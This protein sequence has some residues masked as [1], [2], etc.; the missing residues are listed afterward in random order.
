MNPEQSPHAPEQQPAQP[1]PIMQTQPV[2]TQPQQ[3]T[4]SSPAQNTSGERFAKKTKNAGRT[5]LI[6]GIFI[7]VFSALG[8]LAS[9]TGTSKE[10]SSSDIVIALVGMAVF[11][12]SAIVMIIQGRKL[13]RAANL[14]DAQSAITVSLV[15]SGVILLI[16]IASS[17][18]SQS[19]LSIIGFLT[20]VTIIYLFVVK[21]GI[22]KA[23]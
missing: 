22:K 6:L 20:L 17:V 15:A 16:D 8:L 5:V 2:T 19:G 21:N 12:A 23:V 13:T 4:Q 18:M 9:S 3:F 11:L 1:Q 7:A 14:Q 10:A